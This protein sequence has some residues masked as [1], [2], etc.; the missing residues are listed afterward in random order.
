[1]IPQSK[2]TAM[3]LMYYTEILKTQ[4]HTQGYWGLLIHTVSSE[5]CQQE[6]RTYIIRR[7]TVVVFPQVFLLPSTSVW[8]VSKFFIG[9][10]A[11]TNTAFGHFAG[12]L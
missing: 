3:V 2:Q 4:P 1:M 12:K 10:K 8:P 7:E 9:H 5:F 11:T 6:I